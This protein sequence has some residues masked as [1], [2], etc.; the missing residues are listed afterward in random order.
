MAR[1]ST[2]AKLFISTKRNIGYLISH[3]VKPDDIDDIVQETFVKTYE[4]DLKQEIKYVRSYMLKTAKNLALNHVA[5]WDNKYKD[6]LEEFTEP[7]V[8]LM[9]T[10]V[11][12]DYES[13]EQF[14]FFCRATDQLSGSVRKC[15]I[16]KKVYGLSQ[17]EIASYLK[18]SESTVEKHIAQG[19]LKSSRYIKQMNDEHGQNGK[20]DRQKQSVN[21]KASLSKSRKMNG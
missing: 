21:V 20:A 11:E 4:A 7:P 14:L 3:I 6:S 5:K 19:L 13:K 12:D 10:N 17:K 8:Q 16:L 1:N 9:S 18:L 2:L 15:F